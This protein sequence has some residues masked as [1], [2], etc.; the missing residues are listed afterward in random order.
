MMRD[1]HKAAEQ[2]VKGLRLVAGEDD[3]TEDFLAGVDWVMEQIKERL[4]QLNRLQR[5]NRLEFRAHRIDEL[6]YLLA[7]HKEES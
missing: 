6:L 3:A 7:I 1:A 2:Y 4:E 5:Q